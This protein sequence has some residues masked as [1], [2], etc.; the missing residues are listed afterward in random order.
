[1]KFI[2]GNVPNNNFIPGLPQGAIVEVPA[3]VNSD[4]LHPQKMEELPESVLALLRTQVSIN[5]LL[6]EAFDEKSKNK[7][8]QAIL[9]E[10]TVN[11]YNN[12]VSCMNEMIA[13]KKDV[14]PEFK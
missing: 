1:M 4:G 3:N 12:A 11:S 13:I 14:L 9:L 2:Q 6:V 8:L 7:L 10:P 5:R